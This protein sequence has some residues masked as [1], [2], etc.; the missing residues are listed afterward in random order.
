M[1]LRVTEVDKPGA[2]WD[3]F[4]RRQPRWTFCQLSAW[5]GVIRNVLG[6]DC[7]YLAARPADGKLAGVL[8]LVRVRSLVFG[9]YLVSM[10]FLNYGGPLGDGE[11]VQALVAAAI[12]RADEDGV[13]LLQLRSLSELP[14]DLPAS[15][16]KIT[17][18]L[19]ISDGDPAL[20]WQRLESKV[21]SQVRRP[22]KAGASTA[23]GPDQ[24]E[25]FFQVF[26]RHMRDLGTPTQS[27][28]FF[29]A[30]REAFG[31]DVWFGCV[32]LDGRPVAGGCGFRWGNEFEMSWASSLREYSQVSPNMLLYWSFMERAAKEGVTR[33]N[34]G[35]CNPGSGTHRFKKQWGA[36]D[37]QLW[38]YG[39]PGEASEARTPS[40]DQGAYAIA[41]KLWSR[42]PLAITTTVGPRIVRYIP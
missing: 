33:F 13:K 21:R 20:L 34:F 6:H 39:Y 18:V 12:A 30:I 11:A 1:Q 23:F 17:V 24:L 40:P 22:Q 42:L 19:D 2:E 31:A 29:T 41:A 25:P 27:R 32:Y 28:S 4:V 5:H 8:P 10:P 15:H 37:E 35:R 16:H 7:V 36:L 38:W 26:A 3:A 14:L 9:H